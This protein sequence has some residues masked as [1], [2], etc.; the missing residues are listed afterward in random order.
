MDFQI[1]K[2]SECG[3]YDK[4]SGDFVFGSINRWWSDF[5]KWAQRGTFEETKTDTSDKSSIPSVY[6]STVGWFTNNGHEYNFMSLWNETPSRD[7]KVQ[8]IP[9]D[10]VVN[11]AEALDNKI[12]K[13]TIPGW[14]S[15]FIY[16]IENKYIISISPKNNFS[17]RAL[18]FK[19]LERYYRNYLCKHSHYCVFDTTEEKNTNKIIG[20]R[21]KDEDPPLKYN[22]RFKT[23][24]IILPAQAKYIKDNINS[25][26]KIVYRTKMNFKSPQGY[27]ITQFILKHIGIPLGTEI[28]PSEKTYTFY[29]EIPWIPSSKD[30]EDTIDK[31]SNNDEYQELGVKF[32]F[33]NSKIYWFDKS[34]AK[35]NVI[36][37]DLIERKTVLNEGDFKYLWEESKQTIL[38][39]YPE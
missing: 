11:N 1:Y 26:N 15:N 25:I 13:N 6:C 9:R 28:A 20:Y 35:C 23:S 7:G 8:S 31:W 39:T 38:S 2:L 12:A 30:L 22:I 5:T 29:S 3:F 36:L 18:G 33:D 19:Q 14:A 27:E 10:A 37:D 17:G 4:D 16:D 21:A 32:S 34:L 24:R